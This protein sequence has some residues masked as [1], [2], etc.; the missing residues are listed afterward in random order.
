MI[1]LN[2]ILKG[3]KFFYELIKKKKRELRSAFD[4][5]YDK[6]MSYKCI[7]IEQGCPRSRFPDRKGESKSPNIQPD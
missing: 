3:I 7:T 5:I 2:W 1:P 6:L 4:V